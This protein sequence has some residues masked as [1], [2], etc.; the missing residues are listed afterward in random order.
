MIKNGDYILNTGSF[1]CYTLI[2]KNLS[3]HHSYQRPSYERPLRILRQAVGGTFSP[4]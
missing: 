4:P 3:A 1:L 2:M